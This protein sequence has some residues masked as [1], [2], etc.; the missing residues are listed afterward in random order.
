MRIDIHSHFIPERFIE[1]VRKEPDRFGIQ[2]EENGDLEFFNHKEGFKYPLFRTFY[3][4]SAKLQD[5]E[6]KKL[7]MSVLSA[8]PTIFYYWSD[9]ETTKLVCR[10]YNDS[11][12]EFV[13]A[14]PD[15][16]AGMGIVPLNDP[17]EAILELQRCHDE[18]GLNAIE[19][20]SHVE[21]VQFDDR[22]FLPFFQKV[23][24][25][26]MLVFFHPYYLGNKKGL[27]SYYLTNLLGNL[28][29]TSVSI[30]HIVFGGLLQKFPKLKLYFAH[31][32]GFIPYQ[33]GRLEHGHKVRAE[34]KLNLE[35]SPTEDVRKL[36]FDTITFNPEALK[37]LIETQGEDRVVLGTDFPFD[38]GDEDP[39]SLINSVKGLSVSQKRKIFGENAARL[40]KL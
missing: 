24:E 40:L 20:G 1:E 32:G 6:M 37:F 5:M 17:D 2:V 13:R 18:L 23:E 8:P 12:S 22:R 9:L 30:S 21:G 14:N 35:S 29:D 36:I 16:F 28:I 26:D 11:V 10:I 34:T 15:R 38:M 39:I 33:V 25:L 31:G 19:L 7:D 3:D 4:V 27:E